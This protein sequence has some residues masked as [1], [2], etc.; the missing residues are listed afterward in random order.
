MYLLIQQYLNKIEDIVKEPVYFYTKNT[1]LNIDMLAYYSKDPE[2]LLIE[3]KTKSREC[4]ARFSLTQMPSC[5]MILIF[6]N[7]IVRSKYQNSGIGSILF[8]FKIEIAKQLG[9]STV[10]CT[11]IENNIS[12][13]K[14]LAKN[15]FID[16]HSNINKRT[17]NKVFIS[18]KDIN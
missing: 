1:L 4:I 10:M 14:I 11:D 6:H 16:I 12:Q 3:L 7:S 2:G 5:C 8:E 18:I 13:R 15:D 17:G 9:Y